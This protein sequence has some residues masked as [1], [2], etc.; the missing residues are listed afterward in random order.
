MVIWMLIHN[1]KY[2]SV[3][4]Q[5]QDNWEDEDEEQEKKD[6]EKQDE[7]QVASQPTKKTKK[8]LTR[9]IEEKEVRVFV[10]KLCTLW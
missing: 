7:P 8:N 9:K 3:W 1:I 5:F 10:H 2:N 6:T 4:W